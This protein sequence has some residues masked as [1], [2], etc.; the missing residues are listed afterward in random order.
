MSLKSRYLLIFSY[1]LFNCNLVFPQNGVL[2]NES[3]YNMNEES[4]YFD[5]GLD[6]DI[7]EENDCTAEQFLNNL[8]FTNLLPDDYES[9]RNEKI[10]R[11]VLHV[12]QTYEKY[13]RLESYVQKLSRNQEL[14]KIFNLI[15][16]RAYEMVYEL[17]L[18]PECLSSLLRIVTAIREKKFWALKCINNFLFILG[19]FALK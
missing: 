17:D 9:L 6:E 12:N 16:S 4:E 10:S 1:F 14:S 15:Y 11:N 3:D 18:Q 19:I 13:K 8:N 2:M 7:D 5:I